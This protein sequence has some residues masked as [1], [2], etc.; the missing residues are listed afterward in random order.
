[1]PNSE[2]T[3]IAASDPKPGDFWHDMRSPACLVVARDGN[4]VCICRTTE[5]VGTHHYRFIDPE[6]L[7]LSEFQAWLRYK[8]TPGYW[9]D[10]AERR[11]DVSNYTIPELTHSE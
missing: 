6:W 3:T 2:R 4:H 11:H 10:V 9:A 7:S 5:D 8:K 1:M